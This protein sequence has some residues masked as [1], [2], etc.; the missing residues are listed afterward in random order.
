[1]EERLIIEVEDVFELVHPTGVII[2]PMFI[3]PEG[4]QEQ[5][6]T[7]RVET[8]DG[9]KTKY[10]CRLLKGRFRLA[11]GTHIYRVQLNFPTATKITIPVGSKIFSSSEVLMNLQVTA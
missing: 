3:V 2:T 9:G 10:G 6:L 4:L 8:P 7:V 5:E 11:N 1:M